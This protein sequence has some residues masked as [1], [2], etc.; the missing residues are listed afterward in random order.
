MSLTMRKGLGIGACLL[1]VLFGLGAGQS[2]QANNTQPLDIRLFH[3][4]KH[5][6][7]PVVSPDATKILFTQ[8]RYHY[9]DNNSATYIS[10]VDRV[11]LAKQVTPSNGGEVYANPLWL[12]DQTIGYLHKNKLY[13]QRLDEEEAAV[14]FSPAADISSVSYRSGRITFIASVY[15]NASLA[16]S[17][18]RMAAK[19]RDS[20][21]LYDNLWVRH[22]DEW[23]TLR[24]PTLFSVKLE[25]DKEDDDD[26]VKRVGKEINLLKDMPAFHDPLLRWSVDEYVVDSQGRNAAFV[27]RTPETDLSSKTSVDIYVVSIDGTGKPRLL[28]GNIKGASSAPVFSPDGQRLAWLQIEEQAYESGCKRIYVGNVPLAITGADS[29]TSATAVARDWDCSPHSLVWSQD[30]TTLY[31]IAGDK[32]RNIVFSVDVASGKRRALTETG[33]ASVVRLLDNENLVLVHSNTNRS[34]DMHTLKIGSGEL[35]PLTAV[36]KEALENVYI[37]DAEEFWFTG[38]RGDRV[39]GWLV[40]PF[41][42]DASKTYPLVYLIHGGPQQFS[43]HAFSNSQ[44]N[45]NM[46][47]SAGFVTVQVNFHG[48]SSYGQNFTD[49]I[50]QQWGGYPYEDLMKG[51]D[52]LLSEHGY[53]DRNRMVAL[54]ASYGG[55]MVNWI[56]SQTS[57]FCALVSHDGMFSVPGFWYSTEELWFPEHDF[58]GVPY[59]PKAR[60]HYEQF[61]PERFADNFTT[62]TLFIHGAKDYRLTTEQSLAPFTLLRRKGIAARLMFFPDE[63]HWITHA[64]NSVRWYTEVLRWI[65][66]Y[67]NTTLPYSIEYD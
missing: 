52:Y 67:T 3:S 36:N 13:K 57:R 47:A 44:W 16:E 35:K 8:S 1:H 31:A 54:G 61:N 4:L 25:E 27:V 50:Q 41:G 39:H 38:A 58:G 9:D 59:D 32:G 29:P 48:S 20:A 10:I 30:G 18:A 22:W 14:I 56:N 66:A 43:A 17:K 26:E 55:Y 46:Y 6:G 37:G 19:K 12:D 51:L 64:A 21:Q 53:I 23:I 5:I 2:A 28:T 33:S 65:S 34:S 49:S 15:P 7:A 11:G 42:F 60:S 62:P 40:K 24:K 63:N 45:P